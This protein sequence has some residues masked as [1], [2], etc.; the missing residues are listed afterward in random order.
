MS[1][2]IKYDVFTYQ[3]SPIAKAQLGLFNP[4]LTPEQIMERKNTLFAEIFKGDISFYHRRFKLN[5][6]VEFQDEEVILLRLANRKTVHIEKEFH[7]ESFESE[8]SCLIAIWNNPD[9]QLIAIESDRTSFG[10]SFTVRN[11]VEK[12]FR[13]EL[14]GLNLKVNIHPTYKESDFWDLINTYGGQIERLKFEF[15]YPNLPRV[16]KFLTDELKDASRT[17]NSGKTKLEFSAPDEQIL[18]NV[19]E[20]N[21]ELS[22]LVKASAEGAGPTKLKFKGY[23]RWESTENKVRSV[24]FDELEV[25]ANEETIR[26]YVEVLKDFLKHG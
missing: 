8:P 3:L 25:E 23:K 24:E 15:E 12:S 21:E 7:R 13:R 22:N 14:E 6:K 1:Q 11:I 20:S 16:N 19:D 5:Y 4:N 9:Y 2:P 18:D 10:T 26:N 17:L